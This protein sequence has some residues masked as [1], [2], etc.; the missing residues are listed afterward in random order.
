MFAQVT[1]NINQR[2]K[3]RP[4]D[5]ERAAP[6]VSLLWGGGLAVTEQGLRGCAGAQR[7]KATYVSYGARGLGAD[8]Q[9]RGVNAG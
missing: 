4:C 5:R 9:F 2:P 6:V 8:R 1:P 3:R 7:A